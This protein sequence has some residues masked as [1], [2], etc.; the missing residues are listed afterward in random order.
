MMEQ[1]GDGK[2]DV[3]TPNWSNQKKKSIHKIIRM[4]YT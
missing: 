4:G 1:N 2:S 3:A